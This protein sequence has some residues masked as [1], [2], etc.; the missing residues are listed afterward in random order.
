MPKLVIDD[1]EIEVAPKTMVI[2]A[3]PEVTGEPP[4][5]SV[6]GIGTEADTLIQA[7]IREAVGPDF[8]IVYRLS[9]LDLVPDGNRWDEIVA[10]ARAVEAAG[11]TISVTHAIVELILSDTRRGAADAILP[12]H[13]DTIE[14]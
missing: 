10:Q 8:I 2:E 12:D 4:G 1:R 9:L 3:K 7:G 5:R 6:H 14:L 13:G 11:A